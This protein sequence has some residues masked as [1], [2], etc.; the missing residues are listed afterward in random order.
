MPIASPIGIA[1]LIA[2]FLI[3]LI[4]RAYAQAKFGDMA[5]D[6]TPGIYGRVTLNPLKHLDPMGTALIIL[7]GLLSMGF[8][9]AKPVPLN[10][11]N[12]KNPRWDYFTTILAGPVSSLVLA[13]LFAFPARLLAADPIWGPVALLACS[14]NVS[15]MLFML[16]PIG[17]LDGATLVGLLLPEGPREKW[18]LFNRTAGSMILFGL[19]IGGSL[20]RI[21]VFAFI[22][23]PPH[24][25]IL[26][27]LI[28]S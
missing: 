26:S 21:P 10:P 4:A 5:G 2:I 19:I 12:M 24:S 28:G 20:L 27:A 1:A 9:W 17:A 23:G 6:P 14:V 16:L 18:L 8:G 25:A 3:S 15:L 13:V 11:R 22:I 7:T